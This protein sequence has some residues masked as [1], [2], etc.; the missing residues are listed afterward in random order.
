MISIP[1]KAKTKTK[2][3]RSLTTALPKLVAIWAQSLLEV[4]TGGHVAAKAPERRA[5]HLTAELNSTWGGCVS[6]P[7]VHIGAIRVLAAGLE[8][9]EPS[10]NLKGKLLGRR[11]RR[12][13]RSR[14][15]LSSVITLLRGQRAGGREVLGGFRSK[16]TG[17][18]FTEGFS[19]SLV[20]HL[21]VCS[22]RTRAVVTL[23]HL[24]REPLKTIQGDKTTI[25]DTVHLA[26]LH[27]LSARLE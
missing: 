23:F 11:K 12:A 19:A 3:H 24:R 16:R 21:L 2:R 14:V 13:L 1:P 5:F 18:T 25:G 20:V 10:A 9:V 26:Y 15:E 27:T 22:S 4:S 7:K 6:H 8:S 17:L